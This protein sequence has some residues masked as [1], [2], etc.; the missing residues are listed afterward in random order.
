M[1]MMP[2][3]RWIRLDALDA[4]ADAELVEPEIVAQV[5]APLLLKLPAVL[6]VRAAVLLSNHAA[7]K[8]AV[9]VFERVASSNNRRALLLVGAA[10][11]APNHPVEADL[12]LDL[13]EPGHPARNLLS[14]EPPLLASVLDDLGKVRL[15]RAV[16]ERLGD[17][18]TDP[19][20]PEAAVA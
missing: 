19:P 6:A 10:T 14:A 5:T 3:S 20:A 13:L 8:E 16:R 7:P 15:R 11:L 17:R 18:L 1:A 2:V 9:A 12:V 4:L